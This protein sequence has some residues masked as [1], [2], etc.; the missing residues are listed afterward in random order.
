MQVCARKTVHPFL[1]GGSRV[2]MATDPTHAPT[3]FAYEEWCAIR[4]EMFELG[5][6]AEKNGNQS[7][8]KLKRASLAMNV[9]Q[10]NYGNA[11][12]VVGHQCGR[13]FSERA[14]YF[15]LGGGSLDRADSLRP[16]IERLVD[17]CVYGPPKPPVEVVQDL[18]ALCTYGNRVDHEE[19]DDILPDEKPDLVHRVFRVA[20]YILTQARRECH[21]GEKCKH[22]PSACKFHHK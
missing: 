13:L 21:F 7:R 11:T 22:G 15:L 6:L 20:H 10:E 1:V 18:H 2:D 3:E 4:D 9:A 19:L 5:R 8:C 12:S 14:V 17:D 16:R